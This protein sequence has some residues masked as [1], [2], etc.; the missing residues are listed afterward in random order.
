MWAKP[1]KIIDR[2]FH[3]P[4][5]SLSILLLLDGN[6]HMKFSMKTK[7]ATPT[8]S[9]ISLC[10]KPQNDWNYN[11]W[12]LSLCACVFWRLSSM[13]PS[14]W[15]KTT[16]SFLNYVLK[17]LACSFMPWAICIIEFYI[18]CAYL[19]SSWSSSR[20]PSLLIYSYFFLSS[21][22]LRRIFSF[23]FLN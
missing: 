2:W 10:Q 5:I 12:S 3:L 13:L 23:S 4:V 14:I 21:S 1:F 9:I 15:F 7:V 11:C 8:Q 18:S 22:L 16:T 17:F 20:D 6:H 19:S